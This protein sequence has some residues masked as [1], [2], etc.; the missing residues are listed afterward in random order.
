M[1]TNTDRYEMAHG[2]KPK[3]EGLW[4]FEVSFGNGEGAYASETIS[5]HGLY[6]EAKKAAVEQVRRIPDAK[7][8]LEVKVLA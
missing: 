8:I 5:M 7:M 2:R 1:R 4:M 6:S 3:G